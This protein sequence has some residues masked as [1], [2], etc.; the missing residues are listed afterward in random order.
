ME[1]WVLVCTMTLGFQGAT[2]HVGPV[3]QVL[4]CTFHSLLRGSEAVC[5]SRGLEVCTRGGLCLLADVCGLYSGV[6]LAPCNRSLHLKKLIML[7]LICVNTISSYF[8]VDAYGFH[9]KKCY[10]SIYY[11]MAYAKGQEG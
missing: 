4:T 1:K 8:L 11:V 2:E 9:V 7:T 10:L 6:H 5:E 3:E